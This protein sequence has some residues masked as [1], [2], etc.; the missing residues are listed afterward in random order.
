MH[1]EGHT[2]AKSTTSQCHIISMS[3]LTRFSWE[4]IHTE[5]NIPKLSYYNDELQA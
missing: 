2:V 5:A 3:Q 4:V 1:T